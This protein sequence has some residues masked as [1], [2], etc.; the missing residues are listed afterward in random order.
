MRTLA[1]ARLMRRVDDRLPELS[2]PER[3]SESRADT[4]L[5]VLERHNGEHVTYRQLSVEAG[6]SF[7]TVRRAVA[8]L[9]TQRLVMRIRRVG[10]GSR[11]FDGFV[12]GVNTPSLQAK[13]EGEHPEER[14]GIEEVNTPSNHADEHSLLTYVRT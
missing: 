1:K 6:V 7:M 3:P 9:E 13:S 2:T 4:V 10:P 14:C 11:G 12:W 5:R 8:D